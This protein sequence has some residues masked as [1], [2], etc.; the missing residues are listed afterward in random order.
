MEMFAITHHPSETESDEEPPICLA[1]QGD[2]IAID[3][4]LGL[5]NPEAQEITIFRKGINRVAETLDSRPADL[6]FLVRLHEWAHALLHVGL[7]ETDRLSVTRNES[8]WPAHF[9]RATIWFRALDAN[10]REPLPQLLT[11]HALRS[12]Q[13]QATLPEARTALEA[14]RPYV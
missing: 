3:G 4:V 11:H 1:A 9:A 10:L 2:V 13:A 8:L 5:Y 7:Q 12:L 6:K 14:D